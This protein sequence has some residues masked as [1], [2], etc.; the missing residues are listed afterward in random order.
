MLVSD[1]GS[2]LYKEVLYKVDKII[3]EISFGIKS[4]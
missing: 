3:I 4:S 1:M 2:V